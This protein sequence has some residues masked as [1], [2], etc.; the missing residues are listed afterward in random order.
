MT[1]DA[2][3]AAAELETLRRRIPPTS[4]PDVLELV[5]GMRAT[6]EELRVAEEELS[7]QNDELSNLQL[8]VADEAARYRAL[9]DLAP[10]PYV[11][12]DSHLVIREANDAAAA[13][14]GVD[15]RF[16]G[17]QP[18]AGY[19]GT[20]DRRAVRAGIPRRSPGAPEPPSPPAGL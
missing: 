17:G 15:R 10:V 7:R 16:A 19:V 11:T 2:A 20:G 8:A 12:T 4:D 1:T 13:L 9:F 14:L 18:P 5:E 6:L 3:A